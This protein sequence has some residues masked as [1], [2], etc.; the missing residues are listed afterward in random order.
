MLDPPVELSFIVDPRCIVCVYI[1]AVLLNIPIASNFVLISSGFKVLVIAESIGL[2]WFVSQT[3]DPDL[4][5]ASNNY[6]PHL[7]H[8]IL[9]LLQW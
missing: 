3:L 1:P 2:A 6:T 9:L 8:V 4:V 5:L 7:Y